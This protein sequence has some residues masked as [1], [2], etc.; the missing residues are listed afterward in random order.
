MDAS[1]SD[2]FDKK[3][4]ETMAFNA[5]ACFSKATEKSLYPTPLNGFLQLKLNYNQ[6]NLININKY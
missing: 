6:I 2:D 1:I 4:T 3:R 5:F